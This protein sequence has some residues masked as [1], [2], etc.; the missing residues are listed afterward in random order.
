[1]FNQT[2]LIF[3]SSKALAG[4]LSLPFI[5]AL[6]VI[7]SHE[8]S[9]LLKLCLSLAIVIYG[10]NF[11]SRYAL[12]SLNSSITKLSATNHSL[13]VH[14]KGNDTVYGEIYGKSFISRWF[15]IITI[16][17]PS[18]AISRFPI[19]EDWFNTSHLIVTKFNTQN[20]EQ[21]RRFRVL[22]KFGQ[23]KLIN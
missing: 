22:I 12:I 15:C 23:Q 7:A 17:H 14:T 18:P 2:E 3:T 6:V 4:V 16:K 13:V 5:A 8:L 11:I 20:T 10:F 9:L 19:I 1:M 21:L